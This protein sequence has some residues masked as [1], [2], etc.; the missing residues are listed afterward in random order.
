MAA[1]PQGKFC[2]DLE[3]LAAGLLGIEFQA[4]RIDAITQ[5][6]GTWTVGKDMAEVGI[7][8]G[9]RDFL[10]PHAMAVVFMD[11]NAAGRGRLVKTGPATAGVVLRRGAEELLPAGGTAVDSVGGGVFVL[12]GKGAFRAL[13]AQNVILLGRQFAP[14][15]FVGLPQLHAHD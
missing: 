4:G 2:A 6:R 11:L 10:P 14:P 5:S 12:A 7:A 9:A 3:R 13:F 1:W 8:A 15:L